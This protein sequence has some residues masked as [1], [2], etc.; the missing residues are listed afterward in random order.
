MNAVNKTPASNINNYGKITAFSF[1]FLYPL[2]V[3]P[4]LMQYMI[5]GEKWAFTLFSLFLGLLAYLLIPYDTWD[6]T[7]HYAD[8]QYIKTLS[9]SE[10]WQQGFLH[11]FLNNI[12]WL[13]NALGLPKEFVPFFFTVGAYSAYIK[14][15]F[16]VSKD[17]NPEELN[18][19]NRVYFFLFSFLL[20]NT[21]RFEWVADGLRNPLAFAVSLLGIYIVL[22]KKQPLKGAF[23]IVLSGVIHPSAFLFLPLVRTFL[24]YSY[25]LYT[26]SRF[27]IITFLQAW[28]DDKLLAGQ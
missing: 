28:P 15:L 20:Y 1:F 27:L 23:V 13:V 24:F 11:L 16:W 17:Y 6:I 19:S 4:F 12:M 18:I 22:S 9:F 7:R 25:T 14:V 5:K 10:V 26:L 8:Y 21:I 2:C 3:I